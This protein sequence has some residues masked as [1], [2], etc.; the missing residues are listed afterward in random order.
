MASYPGSTGIRR[1][2]NISNTSPTDMKE[3]TAI[4]IFL[5]IPVMIYGLEEG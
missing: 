4:G 1:S 5:K 2:G 3:I